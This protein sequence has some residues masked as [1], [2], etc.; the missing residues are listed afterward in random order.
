M[1]SMYLSVGIKMKWWYG[2][3]LFLH[4]PAQLNVA[5]YLVEFCVFGGQAEDESRKRKNEETDADEL[6]AVDKKFKDD[7][8]CVA[9][10]TVD[11]MPTS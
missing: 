5:W 4:P 7:S 1:G 3:V 10:N 2:H 8:E 6:N 9:R 11:E